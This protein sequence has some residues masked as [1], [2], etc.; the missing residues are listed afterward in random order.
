MSETYNGWAN[1][2]TWRINLE[3]LDGM[4]CT[5]FGI[6]PEVDEENE[7]IVTDPNDL[8]ERLESYCVELVAMD[9]KPGFAL[10]LALAFLH[11]VDWQEIA[12]NMISD[13]TE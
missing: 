3:M 6:V 5:D 7:Q 8:A 10:G 12:E 9:T 11:K 2:E 1:Y 13:Y 4:S